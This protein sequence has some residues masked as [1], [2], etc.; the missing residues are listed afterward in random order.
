MPTST[1]TDK[2]YLVDNID[3]LVFFYNLTDSLFN[4]TLK[5]ANKK[6]QL[7]IEQYWDK[8]ELKDFYIVDKIKRKLVYTSKVLPDSS[9]ESFYVDIKDPSYTTFP[10]NATIAKF[11]DKHKALSISKIQSGET[12]YFHLLNVPIN[13]VALLVPASDSTRICKQVDKFSIKTQ[14]KNGDTIPFIF[15]YKFCDGYQSAEKLKIPVK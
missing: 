5:I 9:I 13:L 7:Y 6:R 14:K 12:N 2:K 3:S 1:K 15:Q 4:D 10:F 8:G 11:Y